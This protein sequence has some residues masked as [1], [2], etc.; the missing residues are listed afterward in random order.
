MYSMVMTSPS[1][2]LSTPL[3]GEMRVLVMPILAAVKEK[4]RAEEIGLKAVCG[5]V[6]V[7]VGRVRERKDRAFE[8][9]AS[10]LGEAGLARG[11]AGVGGGAEVESTAKLRH[12]ETSRELGEPFLLSHHDYCRHRANKTCESGGL[13]LYLL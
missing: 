3:P 8:A 2:G 5:E 10:V 4:L 11:T 1:L 7:A 12:V 6:K 9:M 13:I